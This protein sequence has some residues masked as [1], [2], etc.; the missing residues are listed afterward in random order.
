[1]L[2]FKITLQKYG[3]QLLN[4]FISFKKNSENPFTDTYKAAIDP[5][6]V[7]PVLNLI[8]LGT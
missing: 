7:L 3:V 6:K 2:K 1:M 5:Y 4:I 8:Q